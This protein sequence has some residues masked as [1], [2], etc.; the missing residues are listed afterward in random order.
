LYYS[1][2]DGWSDR[3]RFYNIPGT[4]SFKL[5]N[6]NNLLLGTFNNY[7]NN[8][9]ITFALGM[10]I[11]S[12]TTYNPNTEL[13]STGNVK[14]VWYGGRNIG[15]VVTSPFLYAP[16]GQDVCNPNNELIFLQYSIGSTNVSNGA[17][18][19]VGSQLLQQVSEIAYANVNRAGAYL[20]PNGNKYNVNSNGVVT[21]I[22][23][24]ACNSS[25]NLSAI[26]SKFRFIKINST[27]TTSQRMTIRITT[28]SVTT[29]NANGCYKF[30]DGTGAY[31]IGKVISGT[32]GSGTNFNITIEQ[33]ACG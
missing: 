2:Y 24:G 27:D 22:E 6:F 15:D 19:I 7:G 21:S 16:T 10:H 11:I 17:P 33:I 28:T 1:N 25:P 4:V 5:Y 29:I 12:Y 20:L 30:V 9:P 8:L 13:C 3:I 32:T 23:V 18:L 14:I 31:I 26:D